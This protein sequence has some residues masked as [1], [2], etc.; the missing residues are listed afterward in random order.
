M[1]LSSLP[2]ASSTPAVITG[3]GMWSPVGYTGPATCAALRAGITRLTLLRDLVD[4]HGEPLA[5]ARVQGL[6]IPPGQAERVGAMAIRVI[7][8]ALQ[9]LSEKAR[10]HTRVS[11]VLGEVERAGEP[12]PV[13][14]QVRDAFAR[15]GLEPRTELAVYPD[16][17]AAGTKALL[18]IQGRLAWNP[19]TTEVL[20][21]ADSLSNVRA[22]G[23]FEEH[24]QLR[25]SQQPRGLHLGEAGACLVLQAERVALA[26]R[27]SRYAAVVGCAV[28]K[29]PVALRDQ[30]SPRQGEGITRALIDAL[31]VAQWKAKAVR[32]AYVDLNGEPCRSHEWMLAATRVLDAPEVI[33]PADCIGDV[34]AASAPLLLGMAAMALHRGYARALKPIICCSSN[35]GLRGVICLEPARQQEEVHGASS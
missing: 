6:D 21:G 5:A 10:E 27:N 17:H 16:G 15:L 11:L 12:S 34:G 8:E 20:V 24:H 23:W 30:G 19:R 2:K 1:T 18:D 9:G 25:E 28:A 29:E 3:L 26:N 4:R 35:A 13:V 22:V 31:E 7:G 33:H 32:R 14:T